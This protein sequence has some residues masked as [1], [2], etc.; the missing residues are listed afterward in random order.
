M[1][2]T[3]S[4]C[5]GAVHHERGGLRAPRKLSGA[6]VLHCKPGTARCSVPVTVPG[7][8][9]T[10]ARRSV[11]CRA[12]DTQVCA[13][14]RRHVAIIWSYF[15]LIFLIIPSHRIEGRFMSV[16]KRG[17][18]SGGRAGVPRR[19]PKARRPKLHG[20]DAPAAHHGTRTAEVLAEFSR[21]CFCQ[22]PQRWVGAG[23]RD[24][25]K[26]GRRLKGQP[27]GGRAEQASK[28]RARDAGDFWRTCGSRE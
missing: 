8:R 7:L 27:T 1:R 14:A 11:L 5:P 24:N 3:F 25:A 26:R 18:G 10:T 12:R 4:Q 13:D 28:H 19:T 6:L 9:R 20:P 23:P 2:L 15:L 22:V 17:T 21:R 16:W